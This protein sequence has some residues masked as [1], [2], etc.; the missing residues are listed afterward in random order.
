MNKKEGCGPTVV[1]P[2]RKLTRC[3]T[4]CLE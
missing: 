4:P 1:N 3:K 2:H